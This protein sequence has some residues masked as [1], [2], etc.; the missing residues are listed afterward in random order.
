MEQTKKIR[1]PNNY[2]PQTLSKRSLSGKQYP[3][4]TI[5]SPKIY[6]KKNCFN[7]N[8]S[9]SEKEINRAEITMTSESTAITDK[10]KNK[11]KKIYI[12]KK[13]LNRQQK[14]L[15]SFKNNDKKITIN[16]KNIQHCSSVDNILNQKKN[17]IRFNTL[18]NYEPN[19]QAMESFY[20][21]FYKINNN[22]NFYNAHDIKNASFYCNTMKNLNNINSNFYKYNNNYTFRRNKETQHKKKEFINIEDLML[23]EEKFR[24]VFVS[25]NNKS[26]IANE[27]FE[28]INYYNQSLVCNKFENYFKDPLSKSIVHSSMILILFDVILIYHISFDNEY[29]RACCDYL[30]TILKLNHNSFLLLC[31]YVC[32]KISSSEKENMWVKKLKIMLNKNLK[33]LDTNNNNEYKFFVLKKNLYNFDLNNSLIEI[34]YYIF[35]TQKYL[36]TIVRNLPD[37]D[38]KKNIIVE[39]YLN[40]FNDIPIEEMNIFFNKQILKIINK[41]ASI[42]GADISV[43]GLQKPIIKEP[44]LNYPPPNKKFT[45]VLDLDE[46]LIS[47]K[48]EPEQNK[49]LL[50]LRP[51]LFEF[52]SSV[53]IFYELVIFTSATQEYADPI[54][55]AIEKG[56][57]IFD[58]KLYRQHTI[59]YNNEFVKDIS[60]LGRPLEKLIIVDNLQQNFRLQKDNGIMIKGFWGEDIYDTALYSLSEILT[61]IAN[62][63]TDARLGIMKYRDEI[64]TKVSSCVS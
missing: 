2:N 12:Y 14:S 6:S 22:S 43:Y 19:E 37:D 30:L 3:K 20:S 49:G 8:I 1:I 16:T 54:L 55:N 61:H 10:N 28:L 11:N 59:I 21:M 5:T 51:G 62:E 50:R 39:R 64:L 58:F 48:I 15:Y 4:N 29:F 44:Y 18:E 63:F 42:I 23:L 34:N 35:S 24:D 45:L 13:N 60:K 53:K 57:K 33:H 40:L 41:N 56:N 17:N 52:L 47:L 32:N 25:I 31:E 38:T 26:N 36:N 46:T 7:S 27:C 9:D